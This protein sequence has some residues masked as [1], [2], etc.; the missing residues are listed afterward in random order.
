MKIR[1]IE[2]GKVAINM[3]KQIQEMHIDFSEKNDRAVT[4][5]A[6]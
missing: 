1:F 5:P 3:T 4:L 2:G 6:T